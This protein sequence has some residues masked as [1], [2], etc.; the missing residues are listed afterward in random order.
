MNVKK[1]IK[2]VIGLGAAAG[3]A[4]LSYKIGESNGEINERFRDKYGEDDE[5]SIEFDDD[6]DEI[7]F[8]GNMDEPDDECLAPEVEEDAEEQS[9]EEEH[10]YLPIEVLHIDGVTI[11]QL[12]GLL[13]YLTTIKKFYRKNVKEYLCIDDDIIID[14]VLECFII[15]GYIKKG[16]KDKYKYHTVTTLADC[17]KIIGW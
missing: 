4:Y 8:Y 1:I 5:D 15:N 17:A 11:G 2:G 14:A 12:R 6:E 16:E 9:G 13:L 7:R 3:I 10:E